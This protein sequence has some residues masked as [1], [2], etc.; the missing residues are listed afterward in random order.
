[1]NVIPMTPKPFILISVALAIVGSLVSARADSPQ[2]NDLARYMP[3]PYV[4]LVHPEFGVNEL[5]DM[6]WPDEVEVIES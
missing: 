4:K 2:G 3:A 5:S 1:M 6:L